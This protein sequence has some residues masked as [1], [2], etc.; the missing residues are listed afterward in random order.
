MDGEGGALALMAK[1][2][3]W[4]TT[5]I[6]VDPW[7]ALVALLGHAIGRKMRPEEACR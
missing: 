5:S 2:T 1:N 3:M 4:E 6:T 7:R